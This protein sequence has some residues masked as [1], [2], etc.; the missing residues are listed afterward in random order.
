MSPCDRITTAI[1]NA[2]SR[3]EPA[4]VDVVTQPR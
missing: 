3:G 2:A 4:L 1:R